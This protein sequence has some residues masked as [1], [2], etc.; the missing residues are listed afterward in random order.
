MRNRCPPDQENGDATAIAYVLR[1]TGMKALRLVVAILVLA[2][3]SGSA[4]AQ[5]LP[6]GVL[7]GPLFP[8]PGSGS[9]YPGSGSLFPAPIPRT[10]SGTH[11][12]FH[13]QFHHGFNN[14]L[15]IFQEPRLVH[16]VLVVH[17]LPAEPPER[18][19][20]PAPPK[21]YVLGRSYASLPGGCMKIVERSA[22]YFRCSGKWYRQVGARYKAVAI[23]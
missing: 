16:D 1:L 17:D 8:Q 4:L 6:G 5:L 15:V 13:R 9:L 7:P 18:A 11:D 10:M 2:L 20:P 21:P 19:P 14:T 23:R 3:T 12:G 22:S